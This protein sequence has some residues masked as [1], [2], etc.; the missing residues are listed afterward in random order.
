MPH[1]SASFFADLRISRTPKFGWNVIA[2]LRR[3]VNVA[4]A[5]AE[6]NGIAAQLAAA[7]PS[8]NRDSGIR[9]I[10]LLD[11]VTQH[12]RL[13]LT[14]MQVAV[15]LVLLIACMNLGNLM[16]ARAAGREREMAVRASLGASR[17]QLAR[18][19]L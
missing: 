2:R 19:L 3:G 18:Q 5:Q 7:W 16:M 1:T 11:Q 4:Q 15:G 9:V 14:L 13:A 8:T 6:M 10:S 12:I 17:L